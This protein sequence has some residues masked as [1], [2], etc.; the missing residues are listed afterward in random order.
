MTRL[1]TLSTNLFPARVVIGGVLALV[2]PK[3]FTWFDKPWIVWGLAVIMLGMG[4]T[5]SVNDFKRVFAMP[6]AVAVGFAAQFAVMPF[7]GWGIAR[8]L[9]LETPLAVGLILVSCWPGRYREPSGRRRLPLFDGE[10]AGSTRSGTR[11][12][13]RATSWIAAWRAVS[14]SR[15]AASRPSTRARAGCIEACCRGR[16]HIPGKARVSAGP[17]S[18][19]RVQ[20]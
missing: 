5:L 15:L 3:W 19:P 20:T 1:M 9:Q 12:P 7:L 10:P 6:R 8:G 16:C 17:C 11:N 18:S 13:R 4:V 2:E 14:P